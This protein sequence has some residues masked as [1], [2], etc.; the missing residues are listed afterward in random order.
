MATEIILDTV[1][2]SSAEM[3]GSTG[4]H[5]R[6]GMAV[7]LDT[8]GSP[9]DL[10]WSVLS[11]PGMPTAGQA[12]PTQPALRFNRVLMQG[13]SGNAVKFQLVYETFNPFGPASAY[14]ITDDT[15]VS[16]YTTN[17]LPITRQPIRCSSVG[18][19]GGLD[20]RE[21][22]VPMS[23]YRPMRAVNV[24][25]LVYGSPDGDPN[26]IHVGE[27]NNATWR[28][29]PVGYWLLMRYYTNFSKYHGYYQKELQAVSRVTEDW[30]ETGILRNTQ[31]GRFAKIAPGAIEGNLANSYNFGY[32][33]NEAATSTH[34]FVRIGPYQLGNFDILF[35]FN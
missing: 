13:A 34:G 5:V 26:G 8:S 33:P 25:A 15:Y 11:L 18:V 29:L 30:S 4:R 27:V 22:F 9:A 20:I 21:D 16:N 7:G 12:H 24:T 2:N 23:F 14:F 28:G 1:E 32:I 6:G 3:F 10:M 35:G 31:T 17:M 19:D